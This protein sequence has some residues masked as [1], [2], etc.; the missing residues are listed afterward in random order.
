MR[1]DSLAWLSKTLYPLTRGIARDAQVIAHFRRLG[2]SWP[3]LGGQ[4]SIY[5]AFMTIVF[6][7]IVFV[8][9]WSDR[10]LFAVVSGVVGPVS[11]FAWA[12]TLHGPS[13]TA[14]SHR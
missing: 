13:G 7:C 10:N 5:R 6:V 4:G 11:V 12:L 9:Q 1:S 3:E 14:P 2:V 8:D